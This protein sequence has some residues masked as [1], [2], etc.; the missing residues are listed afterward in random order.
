MQEYA[1]WLQNNQRCKFS[2]I[3]N[4]P[5]GLVSLVTYAYGN[6]EPSDAVLNSDPNPI[7]TLAMAIVEGRGFQPSG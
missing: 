4:Y 3:A 1:S 7:L 6:L 2:S 5:N